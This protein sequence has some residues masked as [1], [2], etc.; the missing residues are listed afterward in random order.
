MMGK[1]KHMKKLWKRIAALLLCVSLGL[2]AVGLSPVTSSAESV[3]LAGE[4]TKESPWLISSVEDLQGFAAGVNN[5]TVNSAGKYFKLTQ[6]LDLSEVEN[7]TP[8]GNSSTYAFK[9]TFDGDFNTIYNMTIVTGSR[10][11]GLFGKLENAAIKNL[12]IENAEVSVSAN[13][14]AILAGN[15]KGGTISKCYVTGKVKGNGAVSGILG[16]THSSSY[17][18]EIDNCY[19][20]VAIVGSGY[21]KDVA[22]ISGW[23]EATS[24]KLTN[25]FSAC[26]GE[27]RPI[28]GWSDGS[29]VQNSQFVSTYFDKTLSPDFSTEAGRTDLGKTSEELKQPSAYADWDF[30]SVWIMDEN[31]NGGYPY[32][33]GFTSGL[34]GAPGSI[35]V[36]LKDENSGNLVT[37]AEVIAKNQADENDT[38]VFRH[39]GDGV[40]IGIAD[41]TSGTYD[42]YVNGEKKIE[43][44]S[45]DD[46]SGTAK[47]ELSCDAGGNDEEKAE[48]DC[49]RE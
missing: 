35:S 23:N 24:L 19:A 22:G 12:G 34:W 13:D 28:A 27:K 31:V 15:A 9:G 21:T 14:I 26:I 49:R 1:Y 5:G 3:T 45:F 11:S 25:C 2:G 44:V 39:Q 10:Y 43:G 42:I 6:S 38:V 47:L 16:S 33:R 48:V 7:W 18:T 4:G 29:K 37:D 20:R 41:S 8:I 40:Y 46:K 36:T 32:L 17:P 30:D